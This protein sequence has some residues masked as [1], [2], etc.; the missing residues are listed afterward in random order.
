MAWGSKGIQGWENLAESSHLAT[1]R[2]SSP[3]ES[4]TGSGSSRGSRLQEPQFHGPKTEENPGPA[5]FHPYFPAQAEK[6]I[7]DIFLFQGLLETEVPE[8]GA[9]EEC[10]FHLGRK[11]SG[12]QC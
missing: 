9:S 3:P 10:V 7:N 8:A 1:T 2:E 11:S 6:D 5:P 4:G 12:P